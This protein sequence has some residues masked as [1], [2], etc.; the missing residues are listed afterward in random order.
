[1]ETQPDFAGA[2]V[3]HTERSVVLLNLLAQVAERPFIEFRI[4]E[5]LISGKRAAT[6]PFRHDYLTS[7]STH[8]IEEDIVEFEFARRAGEMNGYRLIKWLNSKPF[9]QETGDELGRLI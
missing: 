3:A 2:A 4:R 9:H 1:M 5:A 6:Y 8:Y 7:A